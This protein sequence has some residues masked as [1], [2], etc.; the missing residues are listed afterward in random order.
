NT[1][2][3]MNKP[4]PVEVVQSVKL[5]LTHIALNYGTVFHLYNVWYIGIKL[6]IGSWMVHYIFHIVGLIGTIEEHNLS[7]GERDR[8]E[9]HL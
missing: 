7:L 8:N 6:I 9:G 2:K 3:S 4:G 1:F 5:V